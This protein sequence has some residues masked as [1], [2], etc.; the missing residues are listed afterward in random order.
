MWISG[1][2][3]F[4]VAVIIDIPIITKRLSERLFLLITVDK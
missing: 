4:L 3:K 1:N 2:N